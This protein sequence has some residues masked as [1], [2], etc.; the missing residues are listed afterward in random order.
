MISGYYVKG[1]INYWNAFIFDISS[2]ITSRWDAVRSSGDL[3]NIF[4][5]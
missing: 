3:Y 2:C 4:T 5:K 1:L